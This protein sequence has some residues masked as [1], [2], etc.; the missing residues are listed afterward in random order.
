MEAKVLRPDV[1]GIP[2]SD[3]VTLLLAEHATAR[4]RDGAAGAGAGAGGGAAAAGGAPL[5]GP[6]GEVNGYPR[7]FAEQLRA[8]LNSDGFGQVTALLTHLNLDGVP[9][10]P[11]GVP[12]AAPSAH[13]FTIITAIM[14]A[15][16]MIF[17]HALFGYKSVL[18]GVPL[19]AYIATERA[20]TGQLGWVICFAGLCYHLVDRRLTR[21]VSMLSSTRSGVAICSWT[22]R[23]W[24]SWS[25]LMPWM[26]SPPTT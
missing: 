6:P 18:P 22:S 12:A 4:M 25:G 2:S 8:K 24:S 1:V 17:Y 11:G 23:R 7:A 14:R 9:A 16:E 19:V 3:R 21:R 13:P 10:G 15:R 20:L 26:R 5:A